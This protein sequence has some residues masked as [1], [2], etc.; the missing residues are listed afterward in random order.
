[1]HSAVCGPGFNSLQSPDERIDRKN[2]KNKRKKTDNILFS[3]HYTVIQL[4]SYFQFPVSSYLFVL[5]EICTLSTSALKNCIN[6][7]IVSETLK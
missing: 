6:S 5:S 1:M 7:S 3:I 2:R 4:L